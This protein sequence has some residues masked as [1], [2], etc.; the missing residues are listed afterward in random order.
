MCLH[1]GLNHIQLSIKT[2]RFSY[3]FSPLFSLMGEPKAALPPRFSDIKLTEV[4]WRTT[5]GFPQNKMQFQ[6]KTH[7][8][9]KRK[10]GINND[11]K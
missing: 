1:N 8:T 2:D 4:F 9:Y 10:I 6:N 7:I 3:L 11:A 5:S